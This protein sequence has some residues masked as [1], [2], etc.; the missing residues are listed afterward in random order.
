MK[1]KSNNGA[2]NVEKREETIKISSQETTV[3][4]SFPDEI[5]IELVQ[6]NEL[7]HYELFLWLVALSA[8]IAL[9]YWTSYFSE[10]NRS[11]LWVAI[12]FSVFAMLFVGIAVYYRKKVFHG[13]IK[14][15]SKIS[16]FK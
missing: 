16:D 12:I 3:A 14:K 8:P 4:V 15:V 6:A 11:F 5:A 9:S 13:S 10:K 2:K 1:Q 7:R